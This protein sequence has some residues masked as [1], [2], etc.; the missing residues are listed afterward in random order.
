MMIITTRIHSL[1]IDLS[2]S[3]AASCSSTP[4][5]AAAAA[6]GGGDDDDVVTTSATCRCSRLLISSYVAFLVNYRQPETRIHRNAGKS[7]S[8]Q[9]KRKDKVEQY[10]VLC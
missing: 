2:L 7:G 8:N 6:G 9:R 4:A 5:A 3:T 10:S 1:S